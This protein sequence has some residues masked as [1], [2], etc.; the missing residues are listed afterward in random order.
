MILLQF[1]IEKGLNLEV[2]EEMQRRIFD[3]NGM[4]NTSLTW[5][6]DFARN[7]ADGWKADGSV[8]AH[9]ERSTARAA[10]SMD[11]S[12]ADIAKFAAAYARG[13]GLSAA[14]R[15]ELVKPQL[16]ITTASQ[17]PTLQPEAPRAQPPP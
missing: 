2:G 17:F 14:A 15:A 3:R 16:P 4:V 6:P 10:G 5:R 12:I 7:L 9:D 1:V 11:T 8:E 13:D